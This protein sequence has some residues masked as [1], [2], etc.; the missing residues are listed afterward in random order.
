MKKAWLILLAV[1]IFSASISSAAANANAPAATGSDL[2]CT[3]DWCPNF[4]A[5]LQSQWARIFDGKY[6]IGEQAATV[7]RLRASHRNISSLNGI[8]HFTGLQSLFVPHNQLTSLDL[9]H[10]MALSQIQAFSN[11]LTS[12]ILP[13]N[14]ETLS[15]VNVS[16]N[17]M[18]CH[19]D[20]MG[21]RRHGLLLIFDPQLNSSADA[22]SDVITGIPWPNLVLHVYIIPEE[23]IPEEDIPEEYPN[24][25]PH[26]GR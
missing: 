8:E 1:L 7:H 26:M 19:D 21:W 22:I 3:R 20:V 14:G 15:I 11:Q 23:D 5:V 24:Y 6:I 4:V 12:I 2:I 18:N 9:S 25:N 17:H 13:D 16:G 10:N